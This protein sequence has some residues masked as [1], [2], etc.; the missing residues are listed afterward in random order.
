[1]L[2]LRAP[3]RTLYAPR[4]VGGISGL[5]LIHTK[6]PR[7]KSR[8][9]RERE[10]SQKLPPRVFQPLG[11][12][13]RPWVGPNRSDRSKASTTPT[14]SGPNAESRPTSCRIKKIVHS[15]PIEPELW[16]GSIYKDR[17]RWPTHINGLATAIRRH[18]A[19]ASTPRNAP[20]DAAAERALLFTPAVPRRLVGPHAWSRARLDRLAPRK[21]PRPSGEGSPFTLHCAPASPFPSPQKLICWGPGGALAGRRSWCI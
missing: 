19:G 16:P 4:S 5:I 3:H 14:F 1:M 10:N 20:S 6:L 9:M 18:R 17:M 21:E 2:R 11:A 15:G 12:S 7:K 13:T 8:E